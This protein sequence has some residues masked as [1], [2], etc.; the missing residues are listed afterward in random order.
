[1]LEAYDNCHRNRLITVVLVYCMM[2]NFSALTTVVHIAWRLPA[3]IKQRT[4]ISEKLVAT[5]QK[6]TTLSLGLTGVIEATG[7]A[8]K[9]VSGECCKVAMMASGWLQNHSVPRLCTAK[10]PAELLRVSVEAKRVQALHSLGIL[11]MFFQSLHI[12]AE[13]LPLK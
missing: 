8:E 5:D 11:L 2:V 1:M 3:M 12:S 6:H 4:A 10:R 7:Q 13:H 9:A